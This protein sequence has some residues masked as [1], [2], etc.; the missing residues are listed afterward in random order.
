M[1]GGGIA[2]LT[3]AQQ[4]AGAGYKVYLVEKE[5]QLGGFLAKMAKR[6]PETSAL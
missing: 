4:A 5:A 1:V 3:A 6:A 2:G